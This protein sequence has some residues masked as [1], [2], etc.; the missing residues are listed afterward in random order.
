MD[1]VHF[2]QQVRRDIVSPESIMTEHKDPAA[3]WSEGHR[4]EFVPLAVDLRHFLG[5]RPYADLADGSARA[6][7]VNVAAFRH[8]EQL[9]STPFFFYM[10]TMDP[11]GP[12]DPPPP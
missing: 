3:V 4:F 11:H 2:I 6:D 5:Q 7:E 8:L 10:H 12:L 1:L 9:P